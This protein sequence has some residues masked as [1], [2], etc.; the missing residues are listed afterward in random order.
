M[1]EEEYYVGE[2]K[3]IFGRSG[4]GGALTLC[5]VALRDKKRVLNRAVAGPV[6]VGDLITLLDCE[7]EQRVGR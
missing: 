1:A 3:Q 2:I 5:Q 7:R 4:P 6:R